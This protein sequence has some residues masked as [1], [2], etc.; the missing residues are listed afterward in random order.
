MNGSLEARLL[1]GVPNVK[2]SISKKKKKEK[3][4]QKKLMEILHYNPITGIFY[5]YS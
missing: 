3:L 4:T 2:H 5:I 1:H